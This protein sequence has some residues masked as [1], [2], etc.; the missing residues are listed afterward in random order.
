MII[1]NTKT[2]LDLVIT[3]SIQKAIDGG[4]RF[5]KG[6]RIIVPYCELKQIPCWQ[7]SEK[8]HHY[9]GLELIDKKRKLDFVS[10]GERFK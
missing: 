7:V 5:R 3:K 10:Y 9:V 2:G 4:K 8:C 1:R 6:G